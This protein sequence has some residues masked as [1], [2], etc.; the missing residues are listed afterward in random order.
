MGPVPVDFRL[1]STC[2]VLAYSSG[3]EL[4]ERNGVYLAKLYRYPNNQ[5]ARLLW[6][7]D[8]AIGITRLNA[9]AGIA[10]AYIIRDDVENFLIKRHIIPSNEVPLII[11]DKR[12]FRLAAG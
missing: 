9:Y 8:H 2:L 12:S 3:S 4:P 5:T 7:D 1:R 11:Q 6:Y 10:S